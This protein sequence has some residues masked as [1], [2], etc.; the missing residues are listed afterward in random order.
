MGRR[1]KRLEL[2]Q[3]KLGQWSHCLGIMLHH[4][5]GS[6]MACHCCYGVESDRQELGSWFFIKLGFF[7]G[8]TLKLA[9]VLPILWTARWRISPKKQFVVPVGVSNSLR[10]N[11]RVEKFTEKEKQSYHFCTISTTEVTVVSM[12]LNH[13]YPRWVNESLHRN[14]HL[15][16]RIIPITEAGKPDFSREKRGWWCWYEM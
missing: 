3:C 15:W 5:L 4:S 16:R 7:P 6:Q 12:M 13:L 9:P 2:C 10:G 8:I 11:F 1:L 14:H